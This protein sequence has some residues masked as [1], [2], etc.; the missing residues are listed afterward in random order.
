MLVYCETNWLVA[1]AYPHHQSHKAATTLLTIAQAGGCQL[2]LPYAS[3]LE[4]RH[5]IGNA[6]SQLNETFARVRDEIE[7]AFTNGVT[8]LADLVNALKS[9]AVS[10]YA[11]RRVLT[12]IDDIRHDPCVETFF[13][14]EPTIRLMDEMRLKTKLKGKD[15]MDL[16]L[17]A[18]IVANRR[19][20]PEAPAVFYSTNKSEFDPSKNIV[21]RTVYEQE[22]LLWAHDFDL[23]SSIH[24][25]NSRFGRSEN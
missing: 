22:R 3:L 24:H 5:P 8:A 12:I 7:R 9:D 13:E 23:Q 21:P 17:F 14:P 20:T 10:Q 1:L 15:I 25:W 16:H 11:Q 6:A 19:L 18:A 2:R 4:A